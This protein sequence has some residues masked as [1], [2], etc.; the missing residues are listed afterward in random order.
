MNKFIAIGLWG[1][2]CW[3]ALMF[4]SALQ[5]HAEPI[6][7]M[8]EGILTIHWSDA[9]QAIGDVVYICGK[10]INVSNIGRITFLNFDEQR[11]ANIAGVVFRDKYQNFS[12]DLKDLYQ[13]K[14]VKIRG[15]ITTFRDRPQIVVSDPEQ[16]EIV[17]ELPETVVPRKKT[18]EAG[19]NQI[20]VATYNLLN[21]FD[22]VDDPY[23]AD[24]ST[25][26]K[27]RKQLDQVAATIRT[28]NAD[29]LALQEVES[30][31]YLK[32]FV[33]VFLKDMGYEYIV[34]IEGN[35]LRGIDVCLLSRVPVG[36]VISHRHVPFK[37]LEGHTRRLARD[38]IHV[39]LQ[40]PGSSPIGVWVVH[41]KS[42]FGG[43]EFAEPIR[44]AEAKFVRRQLDKS[45]AA[46]SD[47]AFLVMG[48]FNDI[49]KSEVMQAI[50]GKG[51]N[52]LSMPLSEASMK[53]Q[54]TYNQGPY[55]SMI[56]FILSSPAMSRRYLKGSYRTIPGSVGTSG[57]D[58]NPVSA[59]FLL[60]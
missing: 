49:W 26:A 27:T 2:A 41:L 23:H 12:G 5:V 31:G 24:E 59:I 1:I 8:D 21:L 32:L 18:W 33:D 38:L 60:N 55:K 57:S 19:Q 40:P 22:D 47:A 17:K 16:I 53:S 15:Q 10:I 13:G 29:V 36:P 48:D 50:V 6:M 30:R 14:L 42:N 28:L 4:H 58:H 45:L 39:I 35:D 7:E 44:L 9:D 46:N 11:S 51:S 3:T 34:H 20:V 37:D 43:R 25:P 54:I 56:D 52:A